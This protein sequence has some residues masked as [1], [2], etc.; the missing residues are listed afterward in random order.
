[1]SRLS[2]LPRPRESVFAGGIDPY[3][4]D[5]NAICPPN[6]HECV[7]AMEDCCEEAHEA[8]Q[9]LRNGTFDLPRMRKVLESQRVFLLIDEGTVR[10]YKADLADE[11]EPQI[12][13]LI[14]R[15]E[16]GLNALSRREGLIQSKVEVAQT[17]QSKVATAPTS[18]KREERR[19]QMLAKQRRRLEDEVKVLESEILA[20]QHKKPKRT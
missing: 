10:R 17:M 12:N 18:N 3:R 7:L 5:A 16:K 2:A 4:G 9:L 20:L 13:E 19:L 1:M 15:A 14:D 11:I 6:L 8:Q